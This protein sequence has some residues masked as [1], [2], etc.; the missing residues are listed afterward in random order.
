V[1]EPDT[2]SSVDARVPTNLTRTGSDKD[3][4]SGLRDPAVVEPLTPELA[5]VDPEL[6]R[7]ARDQLPAPRQTLSSPSRASPSHGSLRDPRAGPYWISVV[8]NDRRRENSFGA[9]SSVAAG[10]QPDVDVATSSRE[11]PAPSRHRWR[12]GVF[13]AAL[14]VVLGLAAV[15]ALAPDS[16]VRQ[17]APSRAPKTV[18]TRID[19]HGKERASARQTKR[20]PSEGAPKVSQHSTL[21]HARKQTRA[22]SKRPSTFPTRVFIWPAVS[23]VTLYKV[24]FF[25]GGREVFKALSSKPRL[26]LPLRWT[27]RGRNYHLEAGVYSWR[28]WPAFGSRSRLR[29]GNPIIRSIWV[30]RR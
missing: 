19:R 26:E 30:A 4:E 24:E 12:R 22:T 11:P 5:L 2:F 16:T 14:V 10:A 28:V 18:P 9:S 7:L 21:P 25:R 29:Y 3:C 23:H 15:Y 1:G 17:E 8:D 6:A 20:A 27:Y 13:P